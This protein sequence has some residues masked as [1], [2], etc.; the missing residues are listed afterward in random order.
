MRRAAAAGTAIALV[1][2]ACGGG[3]EP[4][5]TSDGPGARTGGTLTFLTLQEQINHLDP[6]RNYAGEDLAFASGYLHRTLN[7]Y[8]FSADGE[9]ATSLVPD[10]ATDTGM[11]NEDA[12][13][14]SW[15]LKDGLT[16]ED[17][18]D[19]TCEDVKY[20]VSR[21][22]ATDVITDGPLYAISMLDI[23]TDGDGASVY[24]G[25]YVSKGNDTAAFDKAVVCDG[26]T[27]TFN[28]SKPVGDFNYTVTLLS[29]SPV[30]QAAD[31]GAKYDDKPMSSGPYRIQEYSKGS[32]L[33]LERNE[34]WDPETDDYR[35]AYP[36]R[37]VV[38]FGLDPLVIDQRLIGDSG[39]D[40][41][42]LTEGDALQPASL[43]QVFGS[44]EFKDRRTNELDP[45]VQYIA[46]NTAK[47]PNL[48]HRQA[49]AAALDRGLIRQIAGGRFAGPLA[50][51][52]VKPN[53]PADYA[54]SGMWEG[55]LGQPIPDGGDPEY[56]KALIADSGVPMPEIVY[57]YNQ[58]PANDDIAAAVIKSLGA[59]D[60]SVRPNPLEA[61]QYYSIV[62]DPE[63]QGS[64]SAA[65]W[66]PDWSNASTVIPELFTPSGGFNLS[67]ADDA[68]FNEKVEQA[69]AETDREAQAELWKELNKQAMEN[70]WVIPTRFNQ[71]QRVAGS[72]VKAVSGERNSVYLWAPFGSWPYGELYVQD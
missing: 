22:F 16:W 28:L 2:A 45:F 36:D 21:T 70:V 10:L 68:A 63:K 23:P 40:Q 46:I 38:Q 30:P 42:A 5:D 57:D 71:D 31:T 17:G 35:P 11:P 49:I 41:R 43:Q 20:G 32:R 53:L 7:S 19:L 65:G 61:G 12:T 37:I 39:D 59:A 56:A 54:K 47:V 51:G 1:L 50:D 24:K 52:V 6:Q 8:A 66:G 62:L 15:T 29:F 13:S 26:N 3:D 27:I 72:K 34:N 67:Q 25:P 58:T 60:I 64:M 14:W 48:K 55:L 33:V 9:Q 18:S 44:D 4:D 69:K